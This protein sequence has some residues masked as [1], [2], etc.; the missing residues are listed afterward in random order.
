MATPDSL[1]I[2]DASLSQQLAG[3]TADFCDKAPAAAR[4][5][6]VLSG[7]A[8]TVSPTPS[9]SAAAHESRTR[10]SSTETASHKAD[11]AENHE[12]NDGTRDARD[13]QR[14]RRELDGRA[15]PCD[16]GGTRGRQQRVVLTAWR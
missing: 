8:G 14:D 11:K 12:D 9:G 16:A 13:P 2:A 3:P 4:V 15:P 7:S 10:S 5:L 6:V 1:S